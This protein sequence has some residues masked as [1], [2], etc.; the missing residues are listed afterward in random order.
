[1]CFLQYSEPMTVALAVDSR[2]NELLV[3]ERCLH[4]AMPDRDPGIPLPLAL[5]VA[6]RGS[7]VLLVYNRWRRCWELPGG[8]IDPG[9]SPC[10]AAVREFREET[11]QVARDV[12]LAGLATFR[13]MPDYRLEYGAVYLGQVAVLRPFEAND[14]VEQIRWWDGRPLPVL[15]ALDAVIAKA[16]S[17]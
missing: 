6:L 10:E 16:I 11:G 14:E 4:G 3:C 1:M 2:G 15:S 5:M 8:M 12:R 9:E 7:E 13:L 17:S